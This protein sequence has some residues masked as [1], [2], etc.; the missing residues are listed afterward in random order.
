MAG[1]WTD[2]IGW[3][4]IYYFFFPLSDDMCMPC[5]F[6]NA[7]EF[8]VYNIVFGLVVGPNYSI[9]QTM[10]SELSPPGF[11]YMVSVARSASSHSQAPSAQKKKNNSFSVYLDW[12][13]GPRQLLDR[14]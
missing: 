12:R 3:D 13:I 1:I 10:M 8:W 6:H 14:M 5:R 2:N 7:W 9:V 11:E 4:L